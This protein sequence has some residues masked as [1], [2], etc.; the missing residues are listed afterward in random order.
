MPTP[1]IPISTLLKEQTE[2]WSADVLQNSRLTTLARTGRL[3]SRAMAVYLESMRYL[4]SSSERNLARAARR[5]HDLGQVELER[6]FQAKVGEE[7]GHDAW[8][9]DDLEQLPE[10]A[11]ARISPT[12]S[13]VA[14]SALQGH[15]IDRDPICF[16]AYVAWAEYTTALAG[17]GFLDA[18]AGSGYERTQVSSMA[19]H[20]DLDRDHAPA[21]LF[22]LDRLWRGTPDAHTIL[23]GIAQARQF[24]EGFFDE[25]SDHVIGDA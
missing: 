17:D 23:S 19:K 1:P 5:A 20:V 15:L 9:A 11:R 24:F 10:A 3:S 7:Q 25:V 2:T 8:V 12:R 18:L 4:L 22:E 14:L 21:G 16:V 13:I 6:Y